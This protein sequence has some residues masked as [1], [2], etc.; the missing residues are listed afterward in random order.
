MEAC[1]ETAFL[2][3]VKKLASIKKRVQNKVD[4]ILQN[5]VAMGEQLK[6]IWQGFYSCPVKRNLLSFTCSAMSAV[7]RGM[8]PWFYV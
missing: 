3:A 5:P 2:K 7:K 1:F 8:I 4:I 6:G